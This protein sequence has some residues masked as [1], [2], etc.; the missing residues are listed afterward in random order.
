MALSQADS[1]VYP[2]PD[3]CGF[4]PAYSIS[5]FILKAIRVLGI[6]EWIM[7]SPGKLRAVRELQDGAIDAFDPSID[8]TGDVSYPAVE[9]HLDE[10]DGKLLDFL[11]AMA[12][13][14]VLSSEFEYKVYVCPNCVT[15]GMQYST[16][17]TACGSIHTTKEAAVVHPVCGGT[18]GADRHTEAEPVEDEQEVREEG[19]KQEEHLGAGRDIPQEADHEESLYCSN[20][21]EEVLLDDLERDRRYRCHECDSWSDSPTHRLWCRDCLRVYPPGE[22][23]ERPLYRYSLTAVG[24][25]W[26]TEQVEGRRSLVET[27]EARGYET[28]V[29]TTVP[30]SSGGE[31]TVHVYAEDDLLDDRLVADVHD[32][33]TPADVRRIVEAARE[34]D[35]RPI[36]LS[37]DGSVDE[38]VAELLDENDVTLVSS[39]H[40]GLSREYGV[41]EGT[42]DDDRLFGWLDSLFSSST[43][44]R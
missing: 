3:R 29:D 13:R 18:L 6:D 10:R 9:R 31:L 5:Q 27:F 36:V 22:T 11:E 17:C 21:D 14:G 43:T 12:E 35:A 1:I 28:D 40:G 26:L 16:G 19:A 2:L 37:T 7:V 42:R 24:D 20:C 32:S 15:E 23:R 39:T 33:P 8:E 30:T 38:R 44:R 41:R 34:T 4:S 25:R